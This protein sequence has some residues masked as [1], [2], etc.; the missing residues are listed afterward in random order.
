MNHPEQDLI[1]IIIDA[2]LAGVNEETDYEIVSEAYNRLSAD[3]KIELNRQLDE[4]H[5]DIITQQILDAMPPDSTK[6]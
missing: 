1:N 6:H 5:A 3:G 4:I 2:D